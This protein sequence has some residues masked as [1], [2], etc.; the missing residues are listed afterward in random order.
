MGGLLPLSWLLVW[1]WQRQRQRW[2]WQVGGTARACCGSGALNSLPTPAQ[3]VS[4]A[5]LPSHPLAD[6]LPMPCWPCSS[7]GGRLKVS[8]KAQLLEGEW[9]NTATGGSR[10]A[11][12]AKHS[13]YWHRASP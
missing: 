4:P 12:A 6:C 10:A 8:L 1:L 7:S 11:A 13:T 3:P 9:P 2:L 5:H